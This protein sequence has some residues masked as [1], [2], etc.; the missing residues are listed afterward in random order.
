M[1]YGGSVLLLDTMFI[2][3][4]SDTLGGAV[5]LWGANG[6]PRT[7]E[8]IRCT[9]QE[10]QA[11]QGAAISATDL[12]LTVDSCDFLA[13]TGGQGT[14]VYLQLDAIASISNSYFCEHTEADIEGEWINLGG[15]TFETT[16]AGGC[17]ADFDGSGTVDGADL[18]IMLSEWGPCTGPGNCIADLNFDGVVSGA[19]LTIL[20]SEWGPC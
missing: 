12:L 19:D 16:C 13:N 1:H 4:Y 15:N 2:G 7:A 5:R 8:I 6:T 10:N 20:L 11:S 17:D 18:T 14:A 9:F 3:N